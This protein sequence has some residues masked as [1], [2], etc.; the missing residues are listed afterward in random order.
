LRAVDSTLK[1]KETNPWH[2]HQSAFPFPAVSITSSIN[3]SS[4]VLL[5][6]VWPALSSGH[7]LICSSY[8]IGEHTLSWW[9][10]CS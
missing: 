5:F 3:L 4:K 7:T 2:P 9:W 6:T 1:K 8:L 10:W